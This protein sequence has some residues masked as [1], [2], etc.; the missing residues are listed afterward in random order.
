MSLGGDEV[1]FNFWRIDS[2]MAQ[3]VSG[4]IAAKTGGKREKTRFPGVYSR[5]IINKRTGRPDVAFD[6]CYRDGAGKMR[7]QLIGYKSDHVNAAYANKRRGVILDGI[8]RGEKPAKEAAGAKMTFAQGWVLYDSKWLPNL[9]RPEDTRK[10]YEQY[11]EPEFG[12]RHLGSITP[13][14]IED[15]KVK[16][17]Q[18]G[19]AAATVVKIIGDARRM[20]KKLAAWGVYSGPVPTDGFTMP[21]IDNERTR[22]LTEEEAVNLLDALKKRSAT[23]HDIA[24]LSLHTGMRKGEILALR[25]EHLDFGSGRILV[26][27][28][29]TGSRTVYM[30]DEVRALL[31]ARAPKSPMAYVFRPKRTSAGERISRDS[32]ESFVRAVTECGFNKGITDRRHKVVFHT[33]RHTYCSWLA[34]AGVPLFTIG[35]LVG[36]KSVEMTKRYSHLCPDA[37]QAAAAKIGPLMQAARDKKAQESAT[38]DHASSASEPQDTAPPSGGNTKPAHRPSSKQVPRR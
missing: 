21:K 16:L 25:G 28:A 7:W 23:W 2:F 11:L 3:D 15:L 24:W 12:G 36:H 22:Y 34:K 14:D 29:K 10:I 38:A 19:L 33:L 17:L 4:T 13:L 30:T 8:S 35:E 1:R 18:R 27:D 20:Y 37:K 6:I 31:E 9:S 26:K 5:E 32:D